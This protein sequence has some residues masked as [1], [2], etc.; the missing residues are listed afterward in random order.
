MKRNLF[1]TYTIKSLKEST[2][3]FNT[4]Q[5]C[6]NSLNVMFNVVFFDD[7]LGIIAFGIEEGSEN[8]IILKKRGFDTKGA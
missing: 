5:G 3:I 4:D 6:L 8:D 1:K 7:E 2:K